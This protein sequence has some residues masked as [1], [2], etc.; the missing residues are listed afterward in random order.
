G[1]AAGNQDRALNFLAPAFTQHLRNQAR[2]NCEHG[3]VD[4]VG[5][6]DDAAIRFAPEHGVESRMN[7]HDAPAVAAVDE[8]LE[9]RISDFPVLGRGADDRD[10]GGAHDAIHRFQDLFSGRTEA[11][12]WRSEIQHDAHVGGDSSGGRGEYRVQVDLGDLGKIIDESRG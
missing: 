6:I 1:K 4:L 3:N 12:S 9:H 10:G 8:I 5:D 11:L 2:G 7:W